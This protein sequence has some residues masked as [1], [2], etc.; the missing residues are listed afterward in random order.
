MSYRHHMVEV[1]CSKCGNKSIDNM[2]DP[3][4]PS[5]YELRFCSEL[6]RGCNNYFLAF[7][8]IDIKGTSLQAQARKLGIKTVTF[9]GAT[10]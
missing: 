6:D 3:C 9:K 8:G 2:V 5:A 7:P 10:P 1:T 4:D